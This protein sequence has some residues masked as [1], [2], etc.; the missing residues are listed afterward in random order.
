MRKSDNDAIA[1]AQKIALISMYAIIRFRLPPNVVS[2]K[3]PIIGE[4]KIGVKKETPNS[5]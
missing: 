5:P 3:V 1:R 2:N 4:K